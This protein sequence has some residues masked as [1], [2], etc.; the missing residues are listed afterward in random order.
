MLSKSK[1][2]KRKDKETGRASLWELNIYT[3]WPELEQSQF[4]WRYS[5]KHAVNFFG[6][7]I[8]EFICFGHLSGRDGSKASYKQVGRYIS[9]YW[10]RRKKKKK[11]S[12]ISY[13]EN[14]V[15]YSHKSLTNFDEPL[16]LYTFTT[17]TL[18]LDQAHGVFTAS[19]RPC[20][21]SGDRYSGMSL[22]GII[23][24]KWHTSAT[25]YRRF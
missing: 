16:M 6:P 10:L 12:L 20:F 23:Q 17:G 24:R 19:P 18:H 2:L 8:P 13:C 21:T 7:W 9:I 25:L 22:W 15:S 14:F 11:P 3:E 5:I 1:I 4:H